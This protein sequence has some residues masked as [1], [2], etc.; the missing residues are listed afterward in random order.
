LKSVITIA[1]VFMIAIAVTVS[2]PA[3]QSSGTEKA[4][5]AKVKNMADEKSGPTADEQVAGLEAM[6]AA[7][8]DARSARHAKTPLFERLGGEEG[9]HA[10]T[11]ELTR[12]HLENDDINYMFTE[13]DAEKVANH[14]ALFIISGTGGPASYDGP[15]LK[16]SH[17]DMGLTN[18]DFM[19]A[20]GDVIQAMKNLEY[21]Q[22]E[23]DEV[24]CILV[25]L[26]DQ[27]VLSDDDTKRASNY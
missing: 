26:R 17:A 18:A 12:L 1:A 4:A 8:A 16:V 13:L 7:N 25:S 24:V 9:I 15:E 10:F 11:R 5:E 27:V 23:I 19:A 22:D 2:G 21:G 14:V 3:A 20:G 6:C